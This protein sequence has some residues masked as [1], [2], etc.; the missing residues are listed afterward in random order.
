M[1]NS[2]NNF[3]KLGIMKYPYLFFLALIFSI[4]FQCKNEKRKEQS[5]DSVKKISEEIDTFKKAVIT[6]MA[7]D[8]LALHYFNLINN[9]Y[10]F[11]KNY[12]NVTRNFFGDSL[13]MTI[14]SL[15]EPRSFEV[16]IFGDSTYF[17]TKMLLTPGDTITF[18]I[19]N[20]NLTFKGANS[21]YNNFFLAL[22]KHTSFYRNNPYKGDINDYKHKTEIIYNQKIAYLTE[23]KT[24]NKKLSAHEAEL[25][26]DILKYEYLCNLISPRSVYV[27]SAD[28]YINSS[29][30]VLSV[31]NEEFANQED[32]FDLKDYLDGTTIEDFN[33]PDLLQN[34][35]AFKN[36]FDAFIRYYFANNDYLNYSGEAFLNQKQFIQD[37]FEGE[38]EYYAIARMIREY[39]VRGFGYS[40][41][42]IKILKNAIQEYDSVFS[43]KPSY[44]EFMDELVE[45]LNNFDYTIPENALN[46][47]LISQKNDTTSLG[48]IFKN[49]PSKI[50][51][52][53]F[54]ASWCP[55]CIR[56]IKE[57]KSFKNRLAT[58]DN[59]QFIYLSIDK[60]K[61]TWLKRSKELK[62]YLKTEHQYLVLGGK[63]SSLGKSF[64]I[65]GIPRYIILDKEN[66]IV[67]DNAPRPS[68]SLVFKKVIN[69]LNI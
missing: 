64:K 9:G 35:G 18:T 69:R 25:I 5:L 43:K 39:S 12:K 48:E 15:S 34:S 47:K 23:Y 24:Q 13:S 14:D 8:T 21:E 22:Q 62:K 65:S 46:T 26:R 49:S 10:L 41:E 4:L 45:S 16:G 67:L 37:H 42:N 59:V 27:P 57:T 2:T 6:G 17:M 52:I 60:D 7:D 33:R 56:N 50:K 63:N 1:V 58:N 66:K 51:V 29:E 68:D 3:R 28:W 36:T 11:G 40:T 19:R 31:A 44:K 54:W 20:K 61:K 32:L 38:L 55:P 30:G 53:D